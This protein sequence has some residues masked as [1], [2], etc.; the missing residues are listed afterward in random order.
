[1]NLATLRQI[2]QRIDENDEN[3]GKTV[4]M[5]R[6]F[7]AVNM[8]GEETDD[9]FILPDGFRVIMFCYS[10]QLLHICPNFDVFNWNSIML[11]EDASYN[12]CTF[13]SNLVQYSTLRNHFCVFS[14][15]DKIHNIMFYPDDEFY[16]G[17]FKLPVRASTY[18]ETT[19][20]M[21]LSSSEIFSQEIFP[22]K[23]VDAKKVAKNIQKKLPVTFHSK[24]RIPLKSSL[25]NIIRDLTLA[26]QQATILLL[27]CREGEEKSLPKN[28]KV[29]EELVRLY[30]SYEKDVIP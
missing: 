5:D 27:T 1:M 12:Y 24:Y 10:G 11:N 6:N 19:D 2:C 29:Y 15:G 17:I 18:D 25:I 16:H 26:G 7:F 13:L 22:R 4:T 21:Y 9:D 8:H 20:T 23:K 3:D 14:P 30:K 28:P